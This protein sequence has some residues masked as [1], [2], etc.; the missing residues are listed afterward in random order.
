M[1]ALRT[2]HEQSVRAVVLIDADNILIP[3]RQAG[4]PKPISEL[5]YYV[6]QQAG[7]EQGLLAARAYGD[8]TQAPGR[9]YKQECYERS[10]EPVMLVSDGRGE[11]ASGKNTA[12]IQIAVDAME[13]VFSTAPPTVVVLASGDRD[14]VP[15]VQKL[16]RYSVEVWGVGIRG[17]VSQVLREACTRYVDLDAIYE[18]PAPEAVTLVEAPVVAPTVVE[19]VAETPTP[20][21]TTEVATE[22]QAPPEQVPTL[23]PPITRDAAFGALREAVREL[24]DA[25]VEALGSRTLERVRKSL[26]GLSLPELGFESFRT[27]AEAAEKAGLVRVIVPETGLGEMRLQLGHAG[28]ELLEGTP[29]EAC[30]TYRSVLLSHKNVPVVGY[31]DRKALVTRLKA[32]LD[33]SPDGMAIATMNEALSEHAWREGMTW[34][35]RALDKITHTLNIA[36]CFE[37]EGRTD[38]FQDMY[39]TQLKWVPG[40]TVDGALDLMNRVYAQGLHW[41]EPSLRLVPEGLSL[42]LFDD[43]SEHHIRGARALIERAIGPR[44]PEGPLG[45]QLRAQGLR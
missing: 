35:R 42:L 1:S 7:G 18:Q 5:L 37:S 32:M 34:P 9:D 6:K 12:D 22:Q 20:T 10:V 17:C 40:I 26:P 4:L 8:W 21:S 25:G 24:R 23:P 44:A 43:A 39:S 45:Q 16:R 33:E 27:F 19:V 28:P 11:G 30:E 3:A 38:Y 29:Q 14:F 15:L 31:R 41:A 36:R 13:L 2:S